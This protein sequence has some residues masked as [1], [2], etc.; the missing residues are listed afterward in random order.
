VS[1]FDAAQPAA[2]VLVDGPAGA[3]EVDAR[4]SDAVNLALTAGAPI[5]VDSELFGPGV[6]AVPPDGLPGG[7]AAT[8]EIADEARRMMRVRPARHPDSGQAGT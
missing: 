3:H 6:A 7:M 5:R 2:A 1:P 4:P 8:A